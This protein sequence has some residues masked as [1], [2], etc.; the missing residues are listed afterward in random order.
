MAKESEI[1]TVV[2]ACVSGVVIIPVFI[3]WILT[4]A[5]ARRRSDPARNAFVWLK[6]CHVFL[7]A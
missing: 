5:L 2:H 7:I 6:P 4:L 1:W 3:L